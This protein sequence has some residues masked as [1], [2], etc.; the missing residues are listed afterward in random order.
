MET[1]MQV[2]PGERFQFTITTGDGES[3]QFDGEVAYV[4]DGMGFGVKFV[5]LND[6]RQ[7]FLDKIMGDT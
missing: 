5:D 3:Q 2:Q 1:I 6:G 4:F 7:K